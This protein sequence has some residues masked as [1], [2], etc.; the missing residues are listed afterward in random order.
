MDIGKSIETESVLVYERR[1]EA[2]ANQKQSIGSIL[3]VGIK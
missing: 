3:E 2:T 1:E